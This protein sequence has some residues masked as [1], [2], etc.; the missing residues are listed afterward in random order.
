M[1]SALLIDTVYQSYLWL[2]KKVNNYKKF[3]AREL[4]VGRM[5]KGVCAPRKTG[6]SSYWLGFNIINI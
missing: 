3:V 5:V 6:Q 4:G 2:P 1:G